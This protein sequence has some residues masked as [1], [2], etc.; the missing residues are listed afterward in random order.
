[1][2]RL[3][4]RVVKE[5]AEYIEASLAEK[6]R[7][8]PGVRGVKIVE[9]TAR[10]DQIIKD[11][12]EA[13]VSNRRRHGAISEA[14]RKHGLS[15]SRVIAILKMRGRSDLLKPPS[16]WL[17][18]RTKSYRDKIDARCRLA[19]VL[20]VEY[21]LSWYQTAELLGLYVKLK[22]SN[23]PTQ[24]VDTM[25]LVRSVKRYCRRH[26]LNYKLLFHPPSTKKGMTATRAWQAYVTSTGLL[27]E[28]F[29]IDRDTLTIPSDLMEKLNGSKVPAAG[30]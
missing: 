12:A 7:G 27:I 15:R 23:Q 24:I 11:V 1:M 8:S 30:S 26:G 22:V 14:A 13:M 2:R 10:N 28:D 5:V 19:I 16:E 20:R 18:F 17:A 6:T 29:G 3:S 21:K 9:K 25:R 4:T